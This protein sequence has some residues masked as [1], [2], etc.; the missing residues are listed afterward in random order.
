MTRLPRFARTAW[1]ATATTALAG[2]G[3]LL[4]AACDGGAIGAANDPGNTSGQSFVSASYN[5]KFFAP[6]S[7]ELAPAVTGTL[8]TGQHFSLKAERGYVVV[9]NFWG[10]WCAPCRQE[11]PVLGSLAT[12]F[13]GKDVRFIGDNVLD[14]PATAEAFERTFNISY[15]SINDP[16]EQVALAF[17]NSVPPS[18]IPTTL[19]IDRT[20]HIAARVVGEVS[21]DGLKALIGDVLAGKS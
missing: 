19:V 7:R 14:E 6:G 18:A 11:A 2:A 15:P 17:H 13:Q 12:H 4:L 3:I 8:L 1:V 9:M 21:Y 16:G 5:S 10:S 20:G